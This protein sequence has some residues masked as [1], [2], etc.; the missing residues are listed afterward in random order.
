[1]DNNI[2]RQLYET[3]AA[4]VAY[5]AVETK[6]GEQGIGSAFH[7]GEGVFITA[8][9][10]IEGNSIL[11]MGTTERARRLTRRKI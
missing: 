3:Y 9:H 1:M 5:I 2:Y 7:V 6:D 4:A 10:V 8:R 11:K